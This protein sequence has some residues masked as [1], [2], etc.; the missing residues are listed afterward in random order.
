MHSENLAVLRVRNDFDETIMAINDS[1][2]RIPD[3]RELANLHLQTCGLGGGFCH[4]YAANLRL[5]VS[6]S[7]NAALL[8]RARILP[9]Q[10]RGDYHAFHRPGVRELRQS[11]NDV[12]DRVDT[13]FRRLHPFVHWDESA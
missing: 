5:S 9:C 4:A 13:F 11:G 7:R 8:H 2:F 12:A 3:K 6:A 10:L 1:S